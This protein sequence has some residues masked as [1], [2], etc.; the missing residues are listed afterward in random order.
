M[1]KIY[2]ISY[3]TCVPVER[4]STRWP[5]EILASRLSPC[6]V[7]QTPREKLPDEMAWPRCLVR[8]LKRSVGIMTTHLKT[9]SETHASLKTTRSAFWCPRCLCQQSSI[10]KQGVPLCSH[11][12][13]PRQCTTGWI[14]KSSSGVKFLCH[15]KS[16]YEDIRS[17]SRRSI[18]GLQHINYKGLVPGVHCLWGSPPKSLPPALLPPSSLTHQLVSHHTLVLI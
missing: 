14:C 12:P 16:S 10:P 5:I 18:S 6:Y 3:F 11:T 1:I 4:K 8:N 17:G 9:I 7:T 15:K 2:V 13:I